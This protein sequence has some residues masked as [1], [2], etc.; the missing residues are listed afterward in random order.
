MRTLY[1]LQQSSMRTFLIQH[2]LLCRATNDQLCMCMRV[3][4]LGASISKFGDA[5]TSL[6][7]VLKLSTRRLPVLATNIHAAATAADSS[8]AATTMHAPR[9]EAYY[10]KICTSSSLFAASA[11]AAFHS[12]QCDSIHAK[13]P[14]S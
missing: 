11:V 3:H 9:L 10:A 8:L 6:K 14:I 1:A 7:I 4:V 5:L 13:V 2:V 12:H